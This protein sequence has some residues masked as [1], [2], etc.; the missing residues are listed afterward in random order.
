MCFIQLKS[1]NSKQGLIF[2]W[3]NC[4]SSV[5]VVIQKSSNM[6]PQHVNDVCLGKKVGLSNN[7][8][9]LFLLFYSSLLPH[10]ECGCRLSDSQP[11]FQKG[12][13]KRLCRWPLNLLQTK[14]EIKCC[15]ILI[16]IAAGVAAEVNDCICCNPPSP[17][18]APIYRLP[19]PVEGALSYAQRKSHYG[20]NGKKTLNAAPTVSLFIQ[21]IPSD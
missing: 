5:P 4:L 3:L 20:T 19:P 12:S 6:N 2:T 15:W 1:M 10:G 17:H 9:F 18:H 11:C 7:P 8:L 16:R 13:K 21:S 14:P